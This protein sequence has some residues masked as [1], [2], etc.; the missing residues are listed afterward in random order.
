MLRYEVATLCSRYAQATE[1]AQEANRS[2]LQLTGCILASD[3]ELWENEIQLAESYRLTM[4][5]AM[6]ILGARDP[7]HRQE[8]TNENITANR[9]NLEVWVETAIALEEKQL[10]TLALMYEDAANVCKIT[11]PRSLAAGFA[12]WSAWRRR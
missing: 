8:K 12:E 10:V 7:T 2:F 5:E 9:N 4:P 1:I 3:I 6:D 11:T